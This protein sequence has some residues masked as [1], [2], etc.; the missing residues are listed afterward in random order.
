MSLKIT[1]VD[2]FVL[3]ADL[4]LRQTCLFHSEMSPQKP[5]ANGNP[6]TII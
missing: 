6:S 1:S 4:G 3:E 5:S 2:Y